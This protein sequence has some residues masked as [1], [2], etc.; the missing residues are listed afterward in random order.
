LLIAP[1][2]LIWLFGHWTGDSAFH[3]LILFRV[4]EFPL[5]MLFWAVQIPMMMRVFPRDR[6]GQFCSFNAMCST[7]I[8]ILG[9]LVVGE[10]MMQIRRM[11]PDEVWGKDYCYRLAILWRIP[12]L[13]ISMVFMWLLI[14]EWTRLGG[15]K[16]YTPPGFSQDAFAAGKAKGFAVIPATS[17][18]ETKTEG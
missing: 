5:G 11:F 17:E 10:F 8:G 15:E 14:R 6:F 2:N 1:L 12:L 7:F 18:T 13:A 16:T 4:I 9:S 3:S